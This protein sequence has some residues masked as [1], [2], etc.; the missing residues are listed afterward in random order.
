M[1]GNVSEWC[2]GWQGPDPKDEQT[3]PKGLFVST[4]KVIRG[5]DWV[6]FDLNGRSATRD[7]GRI[8]GGGGRGLGF[9][10]ARS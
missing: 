10:L 2:E 6:S 5:G 3:D 9:R 7:S 1:D 8:V 4:K